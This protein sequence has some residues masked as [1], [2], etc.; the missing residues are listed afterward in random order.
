MTTD[1]TMTDVTKPITQP[2]FTLGQRV[3]VETYRGTI[4]FL[5]PVA[6]SSGEWIGVEW[7][8][9]HRGKHSGENKGVQYFQCQ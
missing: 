3:E 6:G 9:I 2:Q 7:D 4:R 5:G 8:D 1:V